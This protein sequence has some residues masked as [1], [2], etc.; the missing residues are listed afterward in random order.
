MTKTFTAI[1][2]NRIAK[3]DLLVM[4]PSGKVTDGSLISGLLTSFGQNPRETL[5]SKE[6]TK[7]VEK[8]IG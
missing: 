7:I 6:P 5:I 2:S 4:R 3:L 8:L 1:I